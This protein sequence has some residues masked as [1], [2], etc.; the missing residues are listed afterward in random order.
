MV[1]LEPLVGHIRA[2][3]STWYSNQTIERLLSFER[4]SHRDDILLPIADD[5]NEQGKKAGYITLVDAIVYEMV[6]NPHRWEKDLV[7]VRVV[8]RCIALDIE[9]AYLQLYNFISS[10][11][12]YYKKEK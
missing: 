6:E 7:E 10:N 5:L 9:T 12:Q 11:P 2:N 3:T 4:I 8:I 1:K